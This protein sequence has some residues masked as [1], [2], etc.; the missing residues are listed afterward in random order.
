MERNS[1][2]QKKFFGVIIS[3]VLC[4][5]FQ[6]VV[7]QHANMSTCHSA[8]ISN[9]CGLLSLGSMLYLGHI[10]CNEHTCGTMYNFMTQSA[11]VVNYL[12]LSC[13]NLWK[14]AD[15]HQS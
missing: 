11:V 14:S 12:G 15:C 13:K 2:E 8:E 7:V 5:V 3:I 4:L 1:I 10:L 6:I 9:C